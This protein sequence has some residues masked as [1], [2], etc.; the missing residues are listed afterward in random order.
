MFHLNLLADFTRSFYSIF[1]AVAEFHSTTFVL[2]FCLHEML[3][4]ILFWFQTF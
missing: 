4:K 1:H 2:S 3:D